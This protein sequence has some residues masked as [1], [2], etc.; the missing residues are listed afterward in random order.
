LNPQSQQASGRRPMPY[1]EEF[2]I[3]NRVYIY[4]TCFNTEIS[5]FGP[6]GAFIVFM[7][8]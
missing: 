8:L 7:L 3:L 5:A 4:S 2:N 1:N 6:H